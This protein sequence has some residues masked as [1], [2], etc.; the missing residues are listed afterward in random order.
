[1]D[2]PVFE[3]G[4]ILQTSDFVDE[5]AYHIEEHRRHHRT[6]H[7]WGI[8]WGL[9]VFH[10]DGNLV[11]EPGSAI[12]GFGRNVILDRV[13][14]LD[15]RSFDIAGIN[16]VDVWIR[17]AQVRTPGTDCRVDLLGDSAEIDVTAAQDID[18]R[19]P[20]GV[21]F[22]D[23]ALAATGPAPDNPSRRW[24]VYLGRVTRDLA[25][26]A[27][28]PVI[29]LD[30]RP[31]IGLVGATV[32]TTDGDVW[33]EL[34]NGS[35]PTVSVG[36]PSGSATGPRPLTVS[37]SKGVE[38]NAE[39]T[40]DGDLVIR[41]GSLSVLPPLVP[42]TTAPAT[43]EWSI[44]HAEDSVAHELRVAM[45]PASGTVPNRLIVGVWRD[46]NFARSLVVDEAGTVMISGNLVVAGY[47]QAASVQEAVVSPAAQAYLAGLQTTNLR[48]L[49]DSVPPV[50]N[51]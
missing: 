19:Q 35:D 50:V 46:G 34:T 9:R 33:L 14:L 4:R 16:T 3:R 20:P 47:L 7:V 27:A 41:G 43:P 32:Q 24:P 36:L 30:Q 39:L 28:A 51:P 26:P 10:L 23:L 45:P 49:F 25:D 1:M 2:R 5:Q 12:D 11:V 29:E 22:A 40:V 37:A 15:L 17:Y 48:S 21:T 8:A 13:H 31:D 6:L 44:S 18:P 38:L 42:A